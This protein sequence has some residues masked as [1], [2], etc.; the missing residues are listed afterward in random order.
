[1]IGWS[2]WNISRKCLVRWFMSSTKNILVLKLTQILPVGIVQVISF[3]MTFWLPLSLSLY[4]SLSTTLPS[5]LP[6]S[7]LTHTHT[8]HTTQGCAFTSSL[9]EDGS[10]Q[11]VNETSAR[12]PHSLGSHVPPQLHQLPQL[13]VKACWGYL[14]HAQKIVKKKQAYNVVTAVIIHLFVFVCLHPLHSCNVITS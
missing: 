14:G 8:H 13:W 1:M 4:I 2:T 10:I 12:P 6:L 11:E 9:L 3:H 5:L 7:S